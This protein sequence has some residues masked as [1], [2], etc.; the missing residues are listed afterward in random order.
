MNLTGKS[1]EQ[2]LSA[3]HTLL[4]EAKQAL[5]ELNRDEHQLTSDFMKL[6]QDSLYHVLKRQDEL[7][8]LLEKL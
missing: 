6:V 5:E 7:I 4:N 8:K 1:K 3:A 2:I